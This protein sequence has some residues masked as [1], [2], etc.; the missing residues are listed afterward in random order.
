VTARP[1][2]VVR[3]APGTTL[4]RHDNTRQS[5][6]ANGLSPSLKVATQEQVVGA[7]PKVG[8]L[9]SATVVLAGEC[10]A[11]AVSPGP[12]VSN[13]PS[14][15]DRIAKE[16]VSVL[17]DSDLH[18]SFQQRYAILYL[19]EEHRG[20]LEILLLLLHESNASKSRMRAQ[21]RPGP[22]ALDGA[23]HSLHVL[24]LVESQLVRTFPFGRTYRLT[25]RGQVLL[26]TSLGSWPGVIAR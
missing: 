19:L 26:T 3:V 12:S 7:A 6:P 20:T 14:A 24:D 10:P 21:L 1:A 9:G 4:D 18:A 8:V 22:E 11:S 5:R 23:L 17:Q 25:E 15:G 13:D 2:R 16:V